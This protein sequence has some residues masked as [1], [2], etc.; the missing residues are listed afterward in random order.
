MILMKDI[1][2]EG[3]PNLT[4]KSV[5]VKLPLS[6]EDLKTLI[7]IYEY[8]INSQSEEIAQKY[9]LRP[10]VGLAAVQINVL[11]RMFVINMDN[12]DGTTYSLALINPKITSKSMETT[13]LPTGEGCLSVDRPTKGLTPRSAKISFE[14]YKLDLETLEVIP[15]K[16]DLDGYAAIVFQHEYDHLDG[17]MFTSK[18]YPDIPYGKPLFELDSDD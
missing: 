3:H 12:F 2:R 6:K 17:I 1:I 13:Y 5:D 4:K 16:M 11:K 8:V 14:A 10:A 15:I 9:K 7:D 18:L